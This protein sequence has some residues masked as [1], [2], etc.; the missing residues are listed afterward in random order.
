MLTLAVTRVVAPALIGLAML[1]PGF[2]QPMSPAVHASGAASALT[3][4]AVYKGWRSRELIGQ[5]VFGKD[6]REIGVV[7]D[8]IM[9]ADGRLA[10]L[11]IE[12]GGVVGLPEAV[13]R[14]P[15]SNVNLTSGEEGVFVD[16]SSGQRPQY[17][18]FPGTEG[19]ATLP[20]EFRLTEVIGDYARLQTGYGFGYVNDVVLSQEGRTIAVLVSRDAQAGGG[21]FA[22]A[23]PGT[24][25]LW[26]P[27]L[28]YYGLPFVTEDQAREAGLRVEVKRVRGGPSSR[29]G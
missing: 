26:D 4:E 16:L 11:V 2:A 23:F 13:Y 28:S 20:R 22:F 5:K 18:L 3:L 29:A 1:S 15:W 17:G 19:V 10:A 21:T 14:I 27:G 25:G 24:T 8:L 12:G 7:R 6:R 9:D